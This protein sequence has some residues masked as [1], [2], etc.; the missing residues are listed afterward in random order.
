MRLTLILFG[1]MFVASPALAQKTAN[2]PTLAPRVEQT[3]EEPTDSQATSVNQDT[4]RR[5]EQQVSAIQQRLQQEE[6]RLQ[7]QF[8][9][10][11]KMR[12]PAVSK[13]DQATLQRI[14]QLEQQVV[15]EYQK[16]VEQ[17]LAGGEEKIPAQP[18]AASPSQ[19]QQ[20]KQLQQSQRPQQPANVRTEPPKRPVLPFWPFNQF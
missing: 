5:L 7:A 16:R 8:A 12:A 9:E 13:A 20:K 6:R 15:A 11:A 14:E 3:A 17:I 18:V 19:S 10:L 2:Q 1:L 4:D